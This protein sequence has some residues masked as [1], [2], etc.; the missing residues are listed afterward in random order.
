MNTP[1]KL[2]EKTLTQLASLVTG[3]QQQVSHALVGQG[4]VLQQMLCAMN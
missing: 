4:E 3:L 1:K 2:D